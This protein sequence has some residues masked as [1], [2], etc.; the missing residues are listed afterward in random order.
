MECLFQ[1]VRVL[2]DAGYNVTTVGEVACP[3]IEMM[4]LLNYL[5]NLM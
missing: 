2:R 1:V 5:L 4:S 3:G